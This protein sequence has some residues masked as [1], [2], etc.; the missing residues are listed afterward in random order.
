MDRTEFFA[1]AAARGWEPGKKLTPQQR[2]G[3]VA[4]IRNAIT[5]RAIE[6]AR[7]HDSQGSRPMSVPEAVAALLEEL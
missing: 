4:D 6:Q 1:L 3:L 7:V 2:M 5:G